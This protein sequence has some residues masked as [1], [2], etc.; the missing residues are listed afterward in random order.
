M[1]VAVFFAAAALATA[2]VRQPP[3]GGGKSFTP[4]TEMAIYDALGK[5]Q[6]GTAQSRQILT[7]YDEYSSAY[8]TVDRERHTLVQ[9]WR[10]LDRRSPQFEVQIQKLAAQWAET[11]RRSVM[12]AGAFD[13]KVASTLT[14]QQWAAWQKAIARARVAGHD[15]APPGIRNGIAP[16]DRPG[17]GSADGDSDGALRSNGSG[18]RFTVASRRF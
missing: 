15:R 5:S 18:I 3:V 7:A 11:Q 12:L 10:R 9:R 16:P 14:P 13:R 6:A 1:R 4:N 2:C 8:E 17:P